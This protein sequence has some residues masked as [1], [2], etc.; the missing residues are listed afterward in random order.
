MLNKINKKGV[1]VGLSPLHY[2]IAFLIV[3]FLVLI[4]MF[5]L[6]GVDDAKKSKT[7]LLVNSVIL[8]EIWSDIVYNSF[9]GKK[10][11]VFL[12]EY[13]DF[14]F[15]NRKNDEI[16]EKKIIN[17]INNSIDKWLIEKMFIINTKI[18]VSIKVDKERSIDKVHALV[19]LGG[20]SKNE[21]LGYKQ[22]GILA[23]SVNLKRNN[24]VVKRVPKNNFDFSLR[25]LFE[26]TGGCTR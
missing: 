1:A 19:C 9:N 21:R 18:S 16:L 14:Y 15:N 13:A 24:V 6:S 22:V 7:D 3:I 26:G 2:L 12:S 20:G 11:Y 17:L 23:E 5:Y 25:I 8:D 10:G 4:F